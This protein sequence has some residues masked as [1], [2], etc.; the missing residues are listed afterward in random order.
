MT[1]HHLVQDQ[2]GE[3][4][5]G[6]RSK[7]LPH[8]FNCTKTDLRGASVLESAGFTTRYVTVALALCVLLVLIPGP[9]K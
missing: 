6:G 2:R 8:T 9:I 4:Q 5:S 3:M 1:R 7:N